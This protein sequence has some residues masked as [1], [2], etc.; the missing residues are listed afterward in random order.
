M[1]T[2]HPALSRFFE[3]LVALGVSPRQGANWIIGPV[4]S[5]LNSRRLE[6]DA[7]RLTPPTLARLIGRVA[8][9]R[10]S[11]PS[12]LQVL[13]GVFDTDGDVDAYG[14]ANGLEQVNDSA[15]VAQTVARVL[16]DHPGPVAD[17]RAGRDKALSFLMGQVMRALGG[18]A[19]P[20]LVNRLLREAL[21]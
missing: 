7:M 10:L 18:R 8:E 1:L 5:G 9:G 20:A 11:R 2:S 14:E 21:A 12:A 19:D 15:V 4:L 3:E 17:Y 16:A 13:E 6:P